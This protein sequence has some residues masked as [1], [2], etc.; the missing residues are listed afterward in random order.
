MTLQEQAYLFQHAA[1]IVG[2]HGAGLTNAIYMGPGSALV[3]L[4]IPRTRYFGYLAAQI[5]VDY[6]VVPEAE[7]LYEGYY[8][9]TSSMASAITA[10]CREAFDQ[11]QA[12]M[13][14]RHAHDEL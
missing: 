7:G 4:P 10:T 3:E 9:I 5:D 13:R 2:P 6:W 1:L 8:T 11:V 14:R 12:N